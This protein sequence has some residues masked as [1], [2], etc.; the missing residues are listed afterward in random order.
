VYYVAGGMAAVA[1]VSMF[2]AVR[3]IASHLQHENSPGIDLWAPLVMLLALVQLAYVAY[4]VQ[5]PDWSTTRVLMIL[6]VALAMVYATALGLSVMAGQ[7]N[8]LIVGLG[9]TGTYP[10]KQITAWCFLILLLLC[11]LAYL[12]GRVTFKWEKAHR[13]LAAGRG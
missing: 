5:L 7:D 10:P 6:S 11:S 8:A 12:W 1:V 3:E 4:A 2:P 9:L 13:L